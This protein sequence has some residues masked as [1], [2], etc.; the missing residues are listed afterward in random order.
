MKQISSTFSLNS[1]H[2]VHSFSGR[3]LPLLFLTLGFT[4][5]F[6]LTGMAL[7]LC[8]PT[9]TSSAPRVL[10]EKSAHSAARTPL[11]VSVVITGAVQRPGV[12]QVPAETRLEAVVA[13]AG[14]VTVEAALLPRDFLGQSIYAGQ[15]IHIPAQGSYQR[16][17]ARASGAVTVK[18]V[19]GTRSRLRKRSAHQTP[20]TKA[21]LKKIDIN[22][23][24]A[25]ELVK[26]PGVGPAL[27]KRIIQ[28]RKVKPFAHAKELIARV[29]GIGPAKYKK[30]AGW[31]K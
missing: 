5:F 14:G 9:Q 3:A 28:A 19:S 26:L 4:A 20:L 22:Q 31:V 16:S 7:T 27:A 8:W 23:A 24:S 10:L 17:P 29:K 12:Y 6:T 15:I 11:T 13:L 21:P 18:R 30:I 1:P 2:Q 25:K